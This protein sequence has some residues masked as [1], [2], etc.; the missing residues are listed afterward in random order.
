M[1]MIYNTSTFLGIFLLVLIVVMIAIQLLGRLV[2][3]GFIGGLY[4]LLPLGC[5]ALSLI[6]APFLHRE[7]FK[8]IE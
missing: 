6:I 5:V 3:F 7:V 2:G 1:K 4:Y 8:S